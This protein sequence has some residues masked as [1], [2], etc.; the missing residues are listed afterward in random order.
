MRA[1][2]STPNPRLGLSRDPAHLPRKLTKL[3]VFRAGHL[4]TLVHVCER[5]DFCSGMG[6]S[7][8]V[9]TYG[10]GPAQLVLRIPL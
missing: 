10:T 1:G 4:E 7:H 3:S 9:N 8:S 6:L 5:R 2:L